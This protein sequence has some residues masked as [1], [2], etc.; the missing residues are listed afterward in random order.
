VRILSNMDPL[1]AA[2][3][4]GDFA[5]RP[6]E[7]LGD[8]HA[9][10]ATADD[11]PALAFIGHS[12]IPMRRVE[13]GTHEILAAR[14]IRK[15]RLAEKAGRAGENIRTVRVA[16]GRLDAPLTIG[17]PALRQSPR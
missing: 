7:R 8:L 10:G 6:G 13:G 4:L 3:E 1:R 12:V 14:N 11:A 2:D 5:T 17:E 9:T 16:L 15:E